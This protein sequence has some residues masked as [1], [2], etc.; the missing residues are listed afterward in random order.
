MVKRTL[1][2][3]SG[4]NELCFFSSVNLNLTVP[5][6]TIVLFLSSEPLA[7]LTSLKTSLAPSSSS[8]PSAFSSFA[9]ASQMVR[10]PNGLC[11]L[12]PIVQMVSG[13]TAE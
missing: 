12:M 6:F 4:L 11:L 10:F 5:S 3:N 9:M 7:S 1:K 13:S 2:F 8:F